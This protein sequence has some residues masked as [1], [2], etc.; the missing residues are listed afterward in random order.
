MSA[1]IAAEERKKSKDKDY[2]IVVNGTPFVV[3]DEVVTYEQ[4][5]GLAFPN[6]DPGVRYSVAFRKAKG[7][8]G[9]SG[10]LPVGGA[11]R[12]K[13]TGTSFD[14]TPTTRS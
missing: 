13:E 14:V 12:V 11:V 7:G 10:T 3:E 5:V 8:H 9:G 1:E 4:I 6:G 2:E